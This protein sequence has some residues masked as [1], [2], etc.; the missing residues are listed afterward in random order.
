MEHDAQDE[1]KYEAQPGFRPVFF[2][3]FG[4]ALL[5]LA[6]TFAGLL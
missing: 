4:V 5:Y 6:L 3:I 1:I 2:T